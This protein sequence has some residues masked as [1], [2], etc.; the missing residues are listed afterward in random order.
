MRKLC[1]AHSRRTGEPCKGLAMANG[2]CKM[3]GGLS[4]GRPIVSGMYTKKA[5]ADRAK[6]RELIRAVK[7]LLSKN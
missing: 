7:T 1:G 6:L 4:T 5:K 3:H 2:R